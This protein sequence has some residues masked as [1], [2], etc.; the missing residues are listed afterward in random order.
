[1]DTTRLAELLREAFGPVFG[2]EEI[3]IRSSDRGDELMVVDEAWT[4]HIEGW[5]DHP[6]AIVA[7]KQEL[8]PPFTLH[9]SR[10]EVMAYEIDEAFAY[11]DAQ[12]EGALTTALKASGD[13][14]SLDLLEAMAAHR[15]RFFESGVE[16]AEVSQ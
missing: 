11:V 10:E 3:D 4:V 1:M 6:V 9:E 14:L 13:P 12:V 15:T 8:E 16:I 7:I 5:P 2:S